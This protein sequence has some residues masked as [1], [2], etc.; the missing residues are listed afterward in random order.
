MIE[1]F[2]KVPV[3]APYCGH[4][5]VDN[6]SDFEEMDCDVNL[7]AV[8]S[9][10]TGKA[11]VSNNETKNNLPPHKKNRLETEKPVAKPSEPTVVTRTTP[12]KSKETVS[13]TKVLED[14]DIKKIKT[15]T[16][17]NVKNLYFKADTTTIDK[18]S[19]AVLDEIY[20]FLKNNKNVRVEIGGHTNGI[21][22]H[23]YCDKLSTSRAKA[24]FDYLVSKGIPPEQMTTK[25]YGKRAL[26]ASDATPS[27]RIKNQRVELKILSVG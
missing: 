5:L 1:A 9:K 6:L 10:V 2:Y 23:E 25:G 12:D 15:G 20:S 22:P 3:L 8:V 16:I 11:I 17:I 18:D 4:I 26:I 21:P 13:K 27:G 7:A 24:V 19:Y 14:L